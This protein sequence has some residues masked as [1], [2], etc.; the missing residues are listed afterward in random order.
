MPLLDHKEEVS[1]KHGSICHYTAA[2]CGR[3]TFLIK[4]LKLFSELYNIKSSPGHQALA[5]PDL[6]PNTANASNVLK[7]TLQVDSLLGKV[8]HINEYRSSLSRRYKQPRICVYP[9]SRLAGTDRN[10]LNVQCLFGAGEPGACLGLG[11]CVV[12]A[13]TSTVRSVLGVD[14]LA[15][16]RE[17][18]EGGQI[19][20][21]D[22]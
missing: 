5:Q 6:R 17:E 12:F 14:A 22:F 19:W 3:T 16:Y 15:P 8:M 13:R 10:M 20:F 9:V 18:G 11:T 4:P 21:P 7:S 2:S 1:Y